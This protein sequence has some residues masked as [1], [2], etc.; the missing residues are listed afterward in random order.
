MQRTQVITV[1]VALFWSS[2]LFVAHATAPMMPL[3]NR[4]LVSWRC[5][6]APFRKHNTIL[7]R[8]GSPNATS[9]KTNN[10]SQTPYA[11]QNHRTSSTSSELDF[12]GTR[13]R[14]EDCLPTQSSSC[15][16]LTP[17]WHW[18]SNLRNFPWHWLQKLHQGLLFLLE[19]M[20]RQHGIRVKRRGKAWP[21]YRWNMLTAIEKLEWTPCD[22][23]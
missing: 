13:W 5:G 15:S 12:S 1:Y 16:S 19:E 17:M 10:L 14:P 21:T 11:S 7:P 3:T 2:I 6:T 23:L 20:T 18:T 4:L 22:L 9:Q 8:D